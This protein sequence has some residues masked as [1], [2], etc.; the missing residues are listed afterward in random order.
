[1]P[2]SGKAQLD[3]FRYRQKR[4]A[5]SKYCGNKLSSTLQAMCD[6]VYNS[7]FKK[8]GREMEMNDY[9][10]RIDE[11]YLLKSPSSAK[12]MMFPRARERFRRQSRGIY[13]ECCVKACALEELKTYCGSEQ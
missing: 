6:G 10:L 12:E 7:M 5:V 9:P 1:M 2:E 13:E 11:L 3:I 8:G 4:H